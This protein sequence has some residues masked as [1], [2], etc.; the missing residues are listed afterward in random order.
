MQV[1][2]GFERFPYQALLQGVVFSGVLIGFLIWAIYLVNAAFKR[3][4]QMQM[5]Q[6]LLDKFSSAHDFAEFM[7]SPAGQKYVMSFTDA[8]TSPRTVILNTLRNGFVLAGIGIGFIVGTN[9]VPLNVHWI[10]FVIGWV[11]FVAGTGFL[12]SATVSFFLAKKA[13]WKEEE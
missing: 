9:A 7:Q 12:I 2:L 5:Q 4:Q 13:V 3:R 8:I 6:R 10:T 1:P 11:A